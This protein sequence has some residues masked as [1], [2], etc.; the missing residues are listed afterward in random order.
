M[1]PADRV[2]RVRGAGLPLLVRHLHS[3]RGAGVPTAQDHQHRGT[4]ED[5]VTSRIKD[6]LSAG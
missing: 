5:P 1:F 6:I 4:Q 3:V 2:R